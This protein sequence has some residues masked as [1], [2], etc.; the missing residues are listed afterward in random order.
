MHPISDIQLAEAARI[1]GAKDAD[2]SAIEE[3][4]RA[5]VGDAMAARRVIDWLPEAFALVL[6]PHVASVDLPTTFSARNKKGKW[7]TFGMDAEPIL[8]GAICLGSHIY[9][10]GPREMFSNIVSRSA[11]LAVV[12]Q[13]LN[14]A[15]DIT[16]ATLSGPAL[17]GVPAEVYLPSTRPFWKKLFR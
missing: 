16:G 7:E 5:L 2:N 4:V 12:D 14:G 17:I 9:R 15:G 8:R 1:I 6:I 10:H 11:L 3:G 13:A